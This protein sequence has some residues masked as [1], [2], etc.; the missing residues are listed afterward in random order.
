MNDSLAVTHFFSKI[1]RAVSR[2][3]LWLA[4]FSAFVLLLSTSLVF[5]EIMSRLMFGKSLVWVIEISEYSLLYMTFLGAPY[6]LEKN[7]HV[8][9]DL[10]VE[11]LPLS[12]RRL[13]VALLCFVAAIACG[14]CAWIGVL[15]TVDQW[16]FGLRETTLM[17]PPSYLITM[18]FPVGMALLSIQFFAQ[19]FDSLKR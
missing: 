11:A 18:V 15:V 10:V 6:L 5:A 16:E 3:N 1:M 12:I 2:I 13:L 17:R 8:A 9:I 14:Y 7:R 19:V 4:W